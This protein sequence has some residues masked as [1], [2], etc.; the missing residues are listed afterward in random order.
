MK[1]AII[2]SPCDRTSKVIRF[3]RGTRVICYEV[4]RWLPQ[5]N[6]IPCHPWILKSQNGK[7]VRLW[8][9]HAK[10]YVCVC[11]GVMSVRW[12]HWRAIYT[13][14]QSTL[15]VSC[16]GK[17]VEPHQ[18]PPNKHLESAE[19]RVVSLNTS[20]N[21]MAKQAFRLFFLRHDGSEMLLDTS[22]TRVPYIHTPFE[23]P[24]GWLSH[25]QWVLS[26]L[27]HEHKQHHKC[28]PASW[29]NTPRGRG[30]SSNYQKTSKNTE[31]SWKLR[32]G[33]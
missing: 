21:R 4:L 10:D 16:S 5:G 18:K 29:R 14:A 2:F 17:R 7:N 12:L 28:R 30:L 20:V 26:S 15:T 24:D 22:E 32:S 27:L 19:Y 13:C 1:A 23:L 25:P 31:G 11:V 8:P 3:N 9:L 33:V 6:A